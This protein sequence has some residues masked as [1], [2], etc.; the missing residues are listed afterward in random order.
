MPDF[1]IAL[2]IPPGR[3]RG[4]CSAV[5]RSP[6]AATDLLHCKHFAHLTTPPRAAERAWQ[7]FTLS[8]MPI[9]CGTATDG[10]DGGFPV[11]ILAGGDWT[12]WLGREDSNSE[13]SWQNI[14][15]KG[16]PDFQGSSRILATETIRV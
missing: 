4:S 12:A 1:F 15:L 7:R 16:R 2:G 6:A 8:W 10:R 11:H 5:P 14:P 3:L 9:K 13:M